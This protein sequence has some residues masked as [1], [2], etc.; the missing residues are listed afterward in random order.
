MYKALSSRIC[1]PQL[2]V[3]VVWCECVSVEPDGGMR[4]CDVT[5]LDAPS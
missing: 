5:L 1:E 4:N 2:C 3:C